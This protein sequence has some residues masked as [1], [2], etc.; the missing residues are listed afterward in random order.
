MRVSEVGLRVR[1]SIDTMFPVSD[2]PPICVRCG[3]PVVVNRDQYE[4]F[5]CMHFLCFHLEFEH[6]TDPDQD[7]GIPGCPVSQT[8]LHYLRD[9]GMELREQALASRAYARSNSDDTFAQGVAHSY[10]VV[11]SSLLQQAA[12]FQIAP[13]T[14]KLDGLDPERDL[15]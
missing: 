14:L 5:E 6:R 4:V 12:A 15:L 2:S 13:Q 11:L 3:A 10:L 8:P 7:C 1:A 9:A